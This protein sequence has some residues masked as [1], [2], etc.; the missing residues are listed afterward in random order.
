MWRKKGWENR[1]K[2][3]NSARTGLIVFRKSLK[4][5]MRVIPSLSSHTFIIAPMNQRVFDPKTTT[6]TVGKITE[7][8]A[9]EHNSE[10]V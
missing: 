10:E 9:E 1:G 7:S 8:I 4:L 3:E 6:A 5:A 2:W